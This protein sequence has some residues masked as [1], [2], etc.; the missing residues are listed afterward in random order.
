MRRP[1]LA[2]NWKMH[3]T[4]SDAAAFAA[5]L[6][7]DVR[8]ERQVDAI[9]APPAT[10]LDHLSRC[11]EGNAIRLAA[12][13]M[14]WEAKGAFTGEISADMLKDLGVRYVIIGH[15]ERR[16]MFGETDASVN[17]KT[18]AAIA[19]GLIPIV[20]VG[21]TLAQREAGQADAIVVRQ[22]NLALQGVKPKEPAG[23][24]I[25][26]EPVWA[27]GTGKVC[28][29][30]EADRIMGVIRDEVARSQG[31]AGADGTRILY[32]GSVKPDNMADLMRYPNIDGGLVG[33]ASLDPDS[34]AALVR[35]SR[36]TP[37]K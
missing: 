14:H 34:F 8:S 12:Q 30:D 16:E 9:I 15:S 28:A 6:P 26:Y 2:G 7:E 21:E 27:I 32:G 3:K 22:T 13:N 5:S 31:P 17:L 10:A 25:A 29:A 18:K 36:P 35:L 37:A 1:V 4:A 33:G 19:A 24:I 20:C 23:L 11:F